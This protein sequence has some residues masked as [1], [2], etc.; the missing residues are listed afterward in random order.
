MVFASGLHGWAFSLSQFARMYSSKLKIPEENLMKRL[1]GDNFYDPETKKWSRVPS[2]AKSERGFNKFIL[3][4][5]MKVY[6]ANIVSERIEYE[7]HSALCVITLQSG[8]SESQS[9]SLC[10]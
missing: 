6:E 7:M 8:S 10:Y 2:S 5:L 1:W 3:E 9:P 4:P